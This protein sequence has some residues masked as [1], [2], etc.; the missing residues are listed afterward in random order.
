MNRILA[1][2]L[3]ALPLLMTGCSEKKEARGKSLP[4]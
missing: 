1:T 3:L 4:R 2:I